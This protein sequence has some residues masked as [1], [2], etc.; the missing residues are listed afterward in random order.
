[1]R[2]D[3]LKIYRN[4]DPMMSLSEFEQVSEDLAGSSALCLFSGKNGLLLTRDQFHMIIRVCRDLGICL[5][6][7]SKAK[8][9]TFAKEVSS[10]RDSGWPVLFSKLRVGVRGNK[11]GVRCRF[12]GACRELNGIKSLAFSSSELSFAL[13][14]QVVPSGLVTL[15]SPEYSIPPYSIYL[16]RRSGRLVYIPVLCALSVE[17]RIRAFRLIRKVRKYEEE[18]L[19]PPFSIQLGEVIEERRATLRGFSKL[20]PPV[21]N[22]VLY[23][24]VGLGDILPLLIDDNVGEFYADSPRTFAYID[25]REL[26]RCESS[27]WV[28]SGAIGRLLAFS[29]GSSRRSSDY[30]NPSIKASIKT[31][32]FHARVSIDAPPLSFE[33][34]SVDVRKFFRDPT[35][36]GMLTKNGTITPEAVSYLL[37]KLREGSSFSIYGESGS[38]KTTLAI[39]LDLETPSHWRKYSVE[40]DIAENITQRHLGKHQVRLIAA[41]GS[42]EAAERRREVLDSLLH[43]SPDYVFFGEVLSESDSRALFQIMASG[44][45]CI[46]TVHAPSGEGLLRRFVYQHHIPLLSLSDLGVLVQMRRFDTG[47]NFTRRV[48]RISEIIRDE[49]PVEMPALRDI[50]VWDAASGQLEPTPAYR[51]MSI[52]A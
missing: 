51:E 10:L 45:R 7:L 20:S 42:A 9:C 17:E 38:G 35:N 34:A 6:L 4:L 29:A 26:G 30:L 5:D 15:G 1:M 25:H 23:S 24:S 40:S 49:L 11:K 8:D 27:V 47:G 3:S 37:A 2:D 44:I 12:C 41:T 33:G 32:E 28:S 46:H 43:K 16:L 52:T 22:F 48:V 21:E 14:P 31:N 50:F 18:H 39:A 19:R 36:F 13:R